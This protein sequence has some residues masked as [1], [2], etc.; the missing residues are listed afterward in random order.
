MKKLKKRVLALLAACAVALSLAV[1]ASAAVEDTGFSD[2]AADAWYA[3]AVA[4]CVENGLMSGTDENVF[5]PNDTMSRAMLAAVLYREAGSPAATGT[6]GFSDVA[7]D[8][9]YGASVRWASQNGLISGYGDGLFGPDDSVSREQMAAILWRAAGSPAPSGAAAAF[10]D[11]AQI[12]GYAV[13]AVHWVRESGLMNGKTGNLFDPKGNATRAEV[14]VILMN[15]AQQPEDEPAPV[16][17]ENAEVLVAYFSNTG[18]TEN[19]AAHI[20]AILDAEL[21]EIVPEDPY[22]AEDLNYNNDDCRANQ[23]QSDA[24]ARPA[25]AGSVENMDE[26]DVVF[27][28]YPIWWGDAPR[29]INTFLESYDFT[30]KTIV[31]FCTSGS[32]GIGSSENTLHALAS[33][34]DWLDGQRFGSGA[35]QDEVAQWVDGLDLTA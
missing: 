8:S 3:Q 2:V 23:E 15:R 35:S 11:A 21:Y 27:L 4:H 20:S 9:W 1:P 13:D 19:V 6:A 32:S 26:Y 10:A 22:T 24:S 33:G 16:P 25:I 5:S 7:D 18:N 30:G 31:P 28:G 14:A 29:I 12:E 17:E 34:A